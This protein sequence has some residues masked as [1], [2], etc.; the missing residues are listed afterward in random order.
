M[1]LL[2]VFLGRRSYQKFWQRIFGRS[3]FF[4]Q[5]IR[6][7]VHN[8]LFSANHLRSSYKDPSFLLANRSN[9]HVRNLSL[10][11]EVGIPRVFFI[12]LLSQKSS[13]PVASEVKFCSFA[14]AIIIRSASKICAS[15]TP[16][17]TTP[18]VYPEA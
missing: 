7:A 12:E 11:S 10:F 16:K 5:L 8:L 3:P 1:F 18:S 13:C 4:Q 6:K 14:P 2:L 9:M 15:M 17:I